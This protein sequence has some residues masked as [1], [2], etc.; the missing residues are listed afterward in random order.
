MKKLERLL[1]ALANHRRLAIIQTLSRERELPVT[2]VAGTIRLS[3]TSTSKHLNLLY[4][5][6]VVDRR[7]ESLVVYY[8]LANPLPSPVR[9]LLPEI[10]EKQ[11]S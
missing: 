10:T 7:Q 2:G 6:D 3:L 1:K 8:R 5:L 11:Y 9:K 4:R